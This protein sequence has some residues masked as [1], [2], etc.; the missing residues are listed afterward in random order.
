MLMACGLHTIR[1]TRVR[2]GNEGVRQ[3]AIRD[4]KPLHQDLFERRGYVLGCLKGTFFFNWE[5]VDLSLSFEVSRVWLE[6]LR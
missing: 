5:V 4:G 6:S 2:T 1:R 3:V